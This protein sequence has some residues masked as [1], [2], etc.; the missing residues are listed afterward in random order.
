MKDL[1]SETRE[2]RRRRRKRRRALRAIGWIGGILLAAAVVLCLLG[3]GDSEETPD[4]VP[5]VAM[6]YAAR[7]AAS[8][9]YERV[10]NLGY[11]EWSAQEAARLVFEEAMTPR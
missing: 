3:A 6:E 2:Q 5:T 7:F 8:E 4:P 9:E 10:L 1:K 11:S